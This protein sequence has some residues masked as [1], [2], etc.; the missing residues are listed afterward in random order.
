M[1]SEMVETI[2]ENARYYRLA[3]GISGEEI[4]KAVGHD[5]SWIQSFEAGAIKKL[6][7]TDL[8]KLAKALGMKLCDLVKPIPDLPRLYISPEEQRKGM[9]NLEKIRWKKR[10]SQRE[11][12]SFLG[13]NADQYNK[14]LRGRANF[15]VKAWLGIAQIL[16]IPL[17]KLLGRKKS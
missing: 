6:K 5:H 2:R 9:E 4:G 12:S 8:R 14:I 13:F 17:E 1:D 16:D 7:T 15:S 10:C 3:K 11:F